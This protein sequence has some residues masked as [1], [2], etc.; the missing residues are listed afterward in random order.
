MRGATLPATSQLE[1]RDVHTAYGH[2]YAVANTPAI[3]PLGEARPNS[4]V[5]R[6]LAARL[7]FTDPALHAS[8]AAIAAAAFN[9]DDPRSAG[10]AC[11]LADQGWARL[12]LPEA[13]APF[14]SGG[15]PT[16]SGKCE[17]FSQSLAERGHDPLPAWIAPHES[18][19][20]NP[21]LAAR[22]P[23]A[24]ISPPARNFLNSSF[25]N[26]PRWLK[27]EAAPCIEIHPA[28]AAARGVEDGAPVRV[29]NAR[30][31][32]RARA[33]VT[34]RIRRGVI[35][36]PSV[37]W[38]KHAGDGQN[39]NAVTSSALTDMGGGPVFYDCL[40]EVERLPD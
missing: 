10:L 33:V 21:G 17:F 22:Y 36:T 19:V 39:A 18:A 25:A 29:H 35:A 3:A 23:L 20:S 13:F 32:F 12:A 34:E 6:L 14:V 15:F 38:Q 31:S 4:E 9:T 2:L 26:L 40:V 30:G 37:W 16:P 1:H 24:M 8:D 28:D 27:K 7:G 5:F 11:G